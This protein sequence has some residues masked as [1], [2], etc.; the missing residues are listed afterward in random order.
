MKCNKMGAHIGGRQLRMKYRRR[1][2]P[3]GKRMA[4]PLSAECGDDIKEP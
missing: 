1:V 2:S 3:N 4:R